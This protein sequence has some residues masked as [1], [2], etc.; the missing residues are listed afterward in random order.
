LKSKLESHFREKK[1][2]ESILPVTKW[3]ST[4]LKHMF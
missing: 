2:V 1:F 3:D 4:M